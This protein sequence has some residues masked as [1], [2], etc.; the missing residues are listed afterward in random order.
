MKTLHGYKPLLEEIAEKTNKWKNIMYSWII[1]DNT[2]EISTLLDAS[3]SI[4][5]TNFKLYYKA[6]IFKTICYWPKDRQIEQWKR[7]QGP[8]LKQHL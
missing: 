8:E 3:Q 7:M 4:T 1:R 6:V 5:P 2:I